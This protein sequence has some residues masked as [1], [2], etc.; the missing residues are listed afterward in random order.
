MVTLFLTAVLAA[1][2]SHLMA[3][4]PSF[5]RAADT[6]LLTV[7]TEGNEARYRVR[8]QL[9]GFDFPNDAVGATRGI[10]GSI[11]LDEQ[12]RVVREAS[13]LT[14]DVTTLKSDRER[15][16]GY[17][18]RRTLETA[19]YPSVTL[20]P[21]ATR[22]MPWPLPASGTLEFE[23]AGDLT[24]KAVT[25]PTTWRVRLTV[26]DGRYTGTAT[27]TFTFADVQLDKPR[28]ASVLSVNDEITLEYDFTLT[29][30]K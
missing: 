12:G 1:P 21:T 13:R 22:G 4:N 9:A 16:D 29:A 19:Q 27:T 6:L 14:I 11:V 25:R 7:A 10:S 15:R 18:Q 23:L 24:V 28:V 17:L 8:E 3:P 2:A 26:L 5:H 30:A 20:V